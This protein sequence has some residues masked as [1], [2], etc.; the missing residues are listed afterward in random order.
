MIQYHDAP[1]QD[2]EKKEG[3]MA[4]W[5]RESSLVLSR[6]TIG[7]ISNWI[8]QPLYHHYRRPLKQILYGN[9]RRRIDLI[10]RFEAKNSPLWELSD[11]NGKKCVH[12]IRYW[13][14]S[15]TRKS[16]LIC[17][18][19]NSYIELISWNTS[20][21]NL[22]RKYKLSLKFWNSANVVVVEIVIPTRKMLFRL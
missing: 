13:S 18:D 17:K 15:Q 9:I 1:D 4:C 11:K 7:S 5:S 3:F 19:S 10:Y 16:L 12:L 20:T 2:G 21:M 8:V 14:E 6:T 22:K